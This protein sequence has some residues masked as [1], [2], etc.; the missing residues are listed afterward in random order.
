MTRGASDP[1]ESADCVPHA[2]VPNNITVVNTTAKLRVA[3]VMTMP[4]CIRT[5]PAAFNIYAI[6]LGNPTGNHTALVRFFHQ[7]HPHP[8]DTAQNDHPRACGTNQHVTRSGA[9]H[10]PQYARLRSVIDMMVIDQP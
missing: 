8:D 9:F 2:H 7:T 4:P 6:A 1:V 3:D 10:L 5:Y